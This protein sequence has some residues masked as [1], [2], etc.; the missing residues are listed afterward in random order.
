LPRG[1]L[2]ISS[3]SDDRMEAKIKT[4]KKSLGLPTKPKKKSLDQKLIPRKSHA[5]TDPL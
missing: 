1:V 2:R 5:E 4:S 3:D